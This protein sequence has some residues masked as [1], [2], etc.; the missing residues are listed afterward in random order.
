MNLTVKGALN[1]LGCAF[2]S[3]ML[4]ALVSPIIPG[5]LWWLP[6]GVLTVL[7]TYA[8]FEHELGYHSDVIYGD[9]EGA[10]N[11]FFTGY[12]GCFV[13]IGVLFLL[14]GNAK[15]DLDFIALVVAPSVVGSWWRH[16][17][18]PVRFSNESQRSE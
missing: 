4:T 14:M 8:A 15:F 9:Y 17:R 13:G 16:Q 2:V 1:A 10:L 7:G 12:V 3:A 5:K 11:S 18:M 6:L